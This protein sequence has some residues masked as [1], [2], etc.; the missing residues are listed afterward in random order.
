ME[1]GIAMGGGKSSSP[2]G[3]GVS[4]QRRGEGGFVSISDLPF[5]ATPPCLGLPYVHCDFSFLL[6]LASEC[7]DECVYQPAGM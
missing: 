7:W 1:K 3:F 6:N 4:A 5:I 2:S